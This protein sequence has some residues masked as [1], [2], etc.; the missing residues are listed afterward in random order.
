[1]G[2]TLSVTTSNAPVDN[3]SLEEQ[4]AALEKEGNLP[5]D[6]SPSSEDR[7]AW[8]PSKFKTVEEMAKSYKELEKRLGSEKKPIPNAGEAADDDAVDDDEGPSAEEQARQITKSA[9]LDFDDMANRYWDEGG[10]RDTD[11]KA[12]EK[13]GIPRRMVDQFIA[14]QQAI[15]EARQN[16]VFSSVGGE[17]QYR[18]MT[19]WAR[20]N[21]D[22]DDITAYDK[23]VS[24]DDFKTIK[25]AV[26][27]LK[28]RYESAVGVEPKARTKG[29]AAQK[30]TGGTYRSWAEVE[31][32]MNDPRYETDPAYRRDV[33]NKLG[34]S[35]LA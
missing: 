19:D 15:V 25:M 35:P 21:L 3:P 26:N 31:K 24:S 28:A 27:G 4:A 5:S 10:L 17:E 23:A 13:K 22:A 14:G 18:A 20:D 29:A 9:G 32:D 6:E 12:L 30:S 16:Q 2:E 33:E 8:L 34:R 1:M 11:Y 7:P